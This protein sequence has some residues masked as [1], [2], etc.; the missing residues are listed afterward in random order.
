MDRAWIAHGSRMDRA[1]IAHGSRMDRAWI[2]NRPR[3]LPAR[4]RYLELLRA[5]PRIRPAKVISADL[6]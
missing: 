6:R 3:A 4:M 5:V 2:A 1:W